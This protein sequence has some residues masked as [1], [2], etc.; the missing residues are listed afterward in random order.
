MKGKFKSQ[1]GEGG[2]IVITK[3]DGTDATETL[4][5]S[6]R[7]TLNGDP[8]TL[9]KLRAG[10]TVATTGDPVTEVKATR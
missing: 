6:V 8:S 10:D 2:N 1:T 4:S 5:G 7:V 9:A 3:D